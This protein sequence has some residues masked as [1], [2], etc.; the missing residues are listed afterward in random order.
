M[1]WPEGFEIFDNVFDDVLLFTF[2]LWLYSRK[3][4][5]IT[6]RHIWSVLEILE[7][8]SAVNVFILFIIIFYLFILRFFI[9]LLF[10]FFE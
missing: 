1:S 3:N 4:S 5:D 6:W 7:I 2:E 10:I 8:Q 9:Y